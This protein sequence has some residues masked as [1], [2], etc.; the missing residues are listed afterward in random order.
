M[1]VNYIWIMDFQSGSIT[2]VKLTGDAL[3]EANECEDFDKFLDK[4]FEK[5]GFKENQVYFMTT[6]NDILDEVEYDTI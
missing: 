5:L 6:E 4:L 3:R 2:K 1:S